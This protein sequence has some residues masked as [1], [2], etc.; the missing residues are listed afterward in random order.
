MLESIFFVITTLFSLLFLILAVSLENW[1]CGGVFANSCQVNPQNY[2]LLPIGVLICISIILYAIAACVDL[3]QTYLHL[4]NDRVSR[5]VAYVALGMSA[6]ASL[7][8]VSAMLAFFN[9]YMGSWSIMLSVVGMTLG[10][11]TTFQM[12]MRLLFDTLGRN[13]DTK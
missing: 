7:F 13:T 5:I 3:A 10:C 12:G 8:V 4:R 9:L 11:S 6:I 1:P 2:A